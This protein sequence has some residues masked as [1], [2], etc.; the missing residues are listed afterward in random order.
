[1]QTSTSTAA[2][3]TSASPQRTLG[4]L[5]TEMPGA[6]RVFER[7]GLDYC[8]G[9]R[10]PFEQACAA[11]G[12]DA[13]AVRAELAALESSPAPD[14]A[15]MSPSEL[16]THVVATHH[17]YLRSEMP[18]LSELATKVAGVHGDR[19]PE[20]HEIRSAYEALRADLLPHLVKEERVLF[21]AITELETATT[22]PWFPFGPASGP[23]SV[24]MLEHDTA[25]ELMER[26]R[27]LTDGFRAP[28][29]GCASYQALYAGLA[30]FEADLHL[31][32]H[33]ENNLLFPAVI[34]LER[35]LTP[36][37]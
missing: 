25:G 30:E 6:A 28:G 32:V 12:V 13:E 31:H 26:I 19:H 17:T 35:A 8:C 15:T 3:D 11:A 22:M 2:G 4:E 20:L 36:T 16:A 34:R 18:R 5:V 9:G 7:H 24:L 23:V 21:P 10:E 37:S 27:V 33:K 29:D 1:M 14:W